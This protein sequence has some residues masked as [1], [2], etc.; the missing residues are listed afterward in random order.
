MIHIYTSVVHVVS[1]LGPKDHLLAF[2]VFYTLAC[3][4]KRNNPEPANPTLLHPVL[5]D[6]D[7]FRDSVDSTQIKPELLST[8]L[9]GRPFLIF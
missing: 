8:T 1:W 2:E 3:T 9:L 6:C 7:T 4:A 5:S